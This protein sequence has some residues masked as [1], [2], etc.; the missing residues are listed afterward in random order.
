[1][2]SFLEASSNLIY[3]VILVIIVRTSYSTLLQLIICYMIILPYAFLMNTSHNKNRVIEYGWKNVFMNLIRK[4]NN[5]EVIQLQNNQENASISRKMDSEKTSNDKAY[6]STHY[7][8]NDTSR[9]EQ[10]S[11]LSSD[12]HGHIPNQIETDYSKEQGPSGCNSL[13]LNVKKLEVKDK[14]QELALKI[15]NKMSEEKDDEKGYLEYFKRLV[16]YENLRKSK[17]SIDV[18]EVENKIFLASNDSVNVAPRCVKSKGKKKKYGLKPKTSKNVLDISTDEGTET[19]TTTDS[20]NT[21]L[22][23]QTSH[24]IVMRIEIINKLS[25]CHKKDLTYDS[26]INELIDLEE[27]FI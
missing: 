18:D 11:E 24:R 21:E 2:V 22:E 9:D 25:S 10:K 1:M 16:S 7:G 27:S 13:V 4:G 3:I 14:K 6:E 23:G 19:K 26:Y 15:I 8:T 20:N 5:S 17:E 12:V